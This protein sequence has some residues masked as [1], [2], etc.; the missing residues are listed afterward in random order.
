M[1]EVKNTDTPAKREISEET[2]QTFRSMGHQLNALNIQNTADKALIETLQQK[3]AASDAAFLKLGDLTMQFTAA[4]GLNTPDGKQIR[5]EILDGTENPMG[6]IM[7]ELS[8]IMADAMA[9][10]MSKTKKAALEARFAFFKQLPEV[11][12]YYKTIS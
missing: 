10:E 11:I 4:F 6:A 5:P 9:S 7:K 1:S 12:E 3:L 8:R 2:F